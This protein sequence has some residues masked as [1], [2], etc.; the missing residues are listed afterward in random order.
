MSVDEGGGRGGG[1]GVDMAQTHDLSGHQ[2]LRDRPPNVQTFE[3]LHRYNRQS[4]SN[5]FDTNMFCN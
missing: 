1:G 2:M 3:L 5:V 4:V